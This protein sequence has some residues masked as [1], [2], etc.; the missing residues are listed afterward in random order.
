TGA[1][2]GDDGAAVGAAIEQAAGLAAMGDMDDRGSALACPRQQRS[3]PRDRWPGV[4]Q[5]EWTGEIFVLDVDQH[6][7][8]VAKT[9]RVE[10]GSGELQQG[11]CGRH[12]QETSRAK[13][14]T[15]IALEAPADM[16]GYCS[17][18]LRYCR[19]LPA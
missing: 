9:R 2:L 11:L 3:R 13:V 18:W 10:I 19:L 15:S 14:S 16:Q 12:G 1:Q 8:G 4:G 5:G 17:W 7:R 6:Q